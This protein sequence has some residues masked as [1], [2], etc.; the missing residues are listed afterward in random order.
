MP[1]RHGN[2][3]EP[4]KVLLD[5]ALPILQPVKKIPLV[6]GE[7]IVGVV[8]DL[9]AQFGS[10]G[11]GRID[12]RPEHRAGTADL[13][14]VS[15]AGVV[16]GKHN[17]DRTCLVVEELGQAATG[18]VSPQKTFVE[19][20]CRRL[21]K[22]REPGLPADLRLAKRGLCDLVHPDADAV[23]VG[24]VGSL[25]VGVQIGGVEPETQ[26]VGRR[27]EHLPFAV[28]LGLHIT[29]ERTKLFTA[30]WMSVNDHL[31]ERSLVAGVFGLAGALSVV[32]E[33]DILRLGKIAVPL[34]V[35]RAALAAQRSGRFPVGE[36]RPRPAIG[37]HDGVMRLTVGHV[38]GVVK[39]VVAQT[40][41]VNLQA[42][43]GVAPGDARLQL[44]R[45]LGQFRLGLADLALQSGTLVVD[46][47]FLMGAIKPR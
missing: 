34:A 35:V 42:E 8:V 47:C 20:Q 39:I 6:L 41:A 26:P 28:I 32:A 38:R 1:Q 11:R 2:R 25:G 40:A 16:G 7:Q 30:Q 23:A 14:S 21:A 3:L 13:E 24:R 31:C 43:P 4:L 44:P 17:H 19:I 18:E 10:L 36:K 5:E 46:Q 9:V 27:P 15:L 22:P 37:R 29:V 33:A 45:Q 12:E